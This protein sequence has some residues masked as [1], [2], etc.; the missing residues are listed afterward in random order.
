MG[1]SMCRLPFAALMK[2]A[3]TGRD[4]VKVG[5]PVLETYSWARSC[6]AQARQ[7]IIMANARGF[8]ER[9]DRDMEAPLESELEFRIGNA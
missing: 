6:P 2:P 4:V 5:T 3:S 8:G 7:I 9:N 1:I